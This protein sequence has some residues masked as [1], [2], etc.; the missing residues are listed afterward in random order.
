M[1]FCLL[2]KKHH[3]QHN[4]VLAVSAK[5]SSFPLPSCLQGHGSASLLPGLSRLSHFGFEVDLLYFFS[6]ALIVQLMKIKL[7]LVIVGGSF[8]YSLIILRSTLDP[9]SRSRF[10]RFQDQ[11][12]VVVEIG[13][14]SQ[15]RAIIIAPDNPHPQPVTDI[16]WP[17]RGNNHSASHVDSP[18]EANVPPGN[19]DNNSTMAKFMLSIEALQKENKSVIS[20]ITKHVGE[21]LKANVL[22]EDQTSVPK[23]H[24]DDN[25]LIDVLPR[26][27]V[28]ELHQ[29][30]KQMALDGFKKECLQVYTSCR[31][32]FLKECLSTFGLQFL[33][34][35]TEDVDDK[36]E[37]LESWIKALNI[38]AR[39]LFPNERKLCHLVFEAYISSWEFVFREICT[40]LAISLL[41]TALALTT[42]SHLIRNSLQELIQELESCTTLRNNAVVLIRQRLCIYEALENVSPVPGGGIHPITLEVMYYIY[43]VYKNRDIR[44]LCQCLEEGKISKPVY[45]ARITELF[46]RKRSWEAKSKSYDNFEVSY[47]MYCVY[48]NKD[49]KLSQGLEEGKLSSPIYMTKMTELLENS[50]EANSKNYNNPTLGYIFIMNNRRFIELEAKLCGLDPIFD[51]DWLQKNTTEF[52]KNLELYKRS[53]WNKILDFLKLDINESKPNVAAELMKQKLHW[54]NEHF[55]ETCNVQSA[56][57]VCDEELREQIIKSIEN[58]LL[59]VYG[60]FLGKF[61]ELLGKHA[62]EYIKYGVFDVQDRVNNLFLVRQ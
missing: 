30:V 7:W 6:G 34:L 45:V 16:V 31:R 18:Q 29:S 42:W 61:Q 19:R 22:D 9:R 5:V 47:Y 28:K 49:N 23:L 24:P 11:D 50:L 13:S 27:I 12:H 48:I 55:D 32:E 46:G 26:G 54:F 10:H 15:S 43:S 8:S 17:S 51:N 14:H 39:I 25:L 59:P 44:K 41:S 4:S 38:A 58:I 33:D 1:K 37:K 2:E 21:Y 35:N 3:A 57:S 40:E 62:Y 60:N 52:Q 20:T 53:S 36:M 56:W